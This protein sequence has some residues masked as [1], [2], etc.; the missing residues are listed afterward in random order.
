VLLNCESAQWCQEIYADLIHVQ[1]ILHSSYFLTCWQDA[2]TIS[3][4]RRNV[5]LE[6]L[7]QECNNSCLPLTVIAQPKTSYPNVFTPT[8]LLHIVCHTHCVLCLCLDT[9]SLF[10]IFLDTS[11]LSSTLSPAAPSIEHWTSITWLD[12][13][14]MTDES[15]SAAFCCIATVRC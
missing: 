6:I 5:R 14:S 4:L 8:I 7:V 1:Q 2:S 11:S 9:F 3:L 13:S 10:H 12:K 15:C